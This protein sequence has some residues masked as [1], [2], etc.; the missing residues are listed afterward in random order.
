MS[1]MPREQPTDRPEAPSP[2]IQFSTDLASL[3]KPADVARR[4][5]V[6]RSWLYEAA[7]TGRIPHVRLGG[8]DGP[9]RFVESDLLAW[10]AEARATWR[11]GRTEPQGHLAD[12]AA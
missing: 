10:L 9:V 2:G 1:P 6:S 11:P 12:A 7:K 3:L 8:S 5:G 4:L